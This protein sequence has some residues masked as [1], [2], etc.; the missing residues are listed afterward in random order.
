MLILVTILCISVFS[1]NVTDAKI[2]RNLPKLDSLTWNR[3]DHEFF[4]NIHPSWTAF[5]Q[6]EM[7]P[8][9]FATDYNAM[10]A[11]FLESKEE[12]QEEVK[13]FFKHKPPT[14][15]SLENARKL[16]NLLRKKAKKKDATD[17]DKAKA[18]QALRQYNYLLNLERSK[19]E[20]KKA[21]LE[22]K[23]FRKIFIKQQ[24]K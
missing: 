13:E 20:S 9:D 12:F 18:N 3:Y 22:E 24:K 16:K 6:G 21:K 4:G 11:S 2:C 1:T 7:S 14:N 8:A 5:T 19:A 10:L 15:N 23:A 17:D